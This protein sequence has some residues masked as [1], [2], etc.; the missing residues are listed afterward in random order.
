MF[1]ISRNSAQHAAPLRQSQVV[2]CVLSSYLPFYLHVETYLC[3]IYTISTHVYAV[4]RSF[5]CALQC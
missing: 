3:S 5:S 2:V 4:L 1:S